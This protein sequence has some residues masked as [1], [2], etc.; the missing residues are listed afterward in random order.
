MNLPMEATWNEAWA[1]CV[2]ALLGSLWE[3][4]LL[5]MVSKGMPNLK[6]SSIHKQELSYGQRDNCLQC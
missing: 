4:L 5:S 2:E 3:A 1:F 6:L